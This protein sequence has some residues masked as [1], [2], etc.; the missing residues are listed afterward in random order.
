MSGWTWKN[1]LPF[2]KS[3]KT[4]A[5]RQST[6]TRLASR[7]KYFHNMIRSRAVGPALGHFCIFHFPALAFTTTLLILYLT[8]VS[9]NPT[10]NQLSALLIAAK[11]HEALIITSLFDIAMY[12][13]RRGL[14]GRRGIPYG[15]LPA[16]FQLTS[17]LYLFT[18]E[19]WSSLRS[20][21]LHSSLLALLLVLSVVLAALAGSSSGIIIIPKLGWRAL[22]GGIDRGYVIAPSMPT[23]PLNVDLSIVP[24]WCVNNSLLTGMTTDHCPYLGLTD[25]GI[26][27]YTNFGDINS[28][29]D[30]VNLTI[31]TDLRNIYYWNSGQSQFA[32]AATTP[33]RSVAYLFQD[34]LF[35]WSF[36][37]VNPI[38]IVADIHDANGD[39]MALKQ[40]RVITHCSVASRLH[41]TDSPYYNFSLSEFYPEFSFTVPE[42]VF[43]DALGS[44][45]NLGFI[46]INEYL[47]DSIDT[48]VA[49]WI[50]TPA[51]EYNQLCLLMCL[52]D[53]RWVE[54]DAWILPLNAGYKVLHSLTIDTTY[55]NVSSAGD[56]LIHIDPALSNLLNQTIYSHVVPIILNTTSVFRL[57]EQT[58][59]STVNNFQ[60][61]ALTGLTIILAEA[62]ANVPSS[63]NWPV[64]LDSN[65]GSGKYRIPNVTEDHTLL[66]ASIYENAYS[67]GFSEITT[68]LSW[69]VLF[70]HYLFVLVHLVVLCV[71]GGRINKKWG[72]LG[73]VISLALNS[74]PAD[75]LVNTSAD[76]KGSKIWRLNATVREVDA[77]GKVELVVRDGKDSS[78]LRDYNSVQSDFRDG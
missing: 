40:P 27:L 25:S 29:P 65:E 21:N 15:F 60:K 30:T 23:F 42:A 64:V 26:A 9:W 52:V 6:T 31:N 49:Y 55:E 72:R 62:L 4:S 56:D 22:S 19:F 17:P 77:E 54:T 13:I 51:T 3:D 73:E 44:E 16:P 1:Y 48:S 7:M 67:Y 38:K 63:R 8:H 35:N 34:T 2:R 57:V 32:A 37:R 45:V 36:S 12:H 39:A 47:P 33:L 53:A 5:N 61:P 18:P 74:R 28:W 50:W 10:A 11:V 76:V 46:D 75:V 78:A 14:L 69:V 43:R 66:S 24:E 70:S 41:E 20:T 68:I 58:L 71:H 59:G